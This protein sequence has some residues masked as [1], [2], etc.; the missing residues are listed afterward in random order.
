MDNS[1]DWLAFQGTQVTES[2]NHPNWR[3][4]WVEENNP[5][6]GL[7]HEEPDRGGDFTTQ[8]SWVESPVIPVVQRV[9]SGWYTNTIFQQ[10]RITFYGAVRPTGLG[11]N[12][13]PP[14][15]RSSESQISAIGTDLISKCAPTNQVA[16]FSTA[17]LD[18]YHDGLPKLLGSL[19]WKDRAARVR[20]VYKNAGNEYLNSEF[21]WKPLVKDV[22][23]LSSG[24][25][26]LD[27]LV[28]QYI[29]DA[30]K[31]VRRKYG[32]PPIV[33]TEYSTFVPQA[34]AA[35]VGGADNSLL[36]QVFPFRGS[37]QRTRQTTIFRWFSGA[38]TY[39]LPANTGDVFGEHAR[40][41]EQLL[42]VELTPEVL[43]ELT[44]WSWAV[45]WFAN[46]GNVIHNAQRWSSDG[47][48]MRYGYVMEKSTVRDTYSHVGSTGL[49]PGNLAFP[50]SYVFVTETKLRRRATPFGF[51]INFAALTGQ[52][53]AISAALGLSRIR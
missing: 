7:F 43:W 34:V 24:V 29:K 50:E 35:L 41:A 11:G 53:K 2:E 10:Q 18:T 22:T 21:G 13:F 48:V 28:K 45:D 38:F 23:D 37:V 5:G 17:L 46:L 3:Q 32:F 52:Q 42:G 16:N 27:K 31:V 40:L 6:S 26:H 49:K 36:D 33:K 15:A 25:L 4:T 1:E 30:G 19:F 20:D 8:K 9:T 39:H 12:I 44:P 14:S 47:L 51:G